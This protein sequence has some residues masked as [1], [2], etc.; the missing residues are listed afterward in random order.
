MEEK[1]PTARDILLI[2]ALLAFFLIFI[3]GL[4]TLFNWI[5]NTFT[6]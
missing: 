1:E 3:L 2:L 5:V 6:R 4:V